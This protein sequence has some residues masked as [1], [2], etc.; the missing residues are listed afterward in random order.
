MVYAFFLHKTLTFL[1]TEFTSNFIHEKFGLQYLY[2][3]MSI[4]CHIRELASFLTLS[5]EDYFSRNVSNFDDIN[6]L[7]LRLNGLY[8]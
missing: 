6:R 5:R 2:P 3:S 7:W 4:F 8:D 1:G